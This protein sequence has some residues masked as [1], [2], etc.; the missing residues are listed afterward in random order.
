MKQME[1]AMP[2]N[3]EPI[4]FDKL[5]NLEEDLA[6]IDAEFGEAI[7]GGDIEQARRDVIVSL[8]SMRQTNLQFGIALSRYKQYYKA[9]QN[10]MTVLNRIA[11]E[12]G[13][14]A[15]TLERLIE[16]CEHARSL[17][18]LVIQAMIELKINPAETKHAALIQNLAQ[19]PAPPSREEAAAAVKMAN[20]QHISRKRVARTAKTS[21]DSA[22]LSE[23][24]A[25]AIRLFRLRYRETISAS[26]K[27]EIRQVLGG[28]AS[29]FEIDAAA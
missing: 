14:C 4:K 23:F 5:S 20:D 3:G 6:A 15:R 17:P 18:S 21:A 13:R 27:A 10:W 8:D 25:K 22:P 7:E 28:I 24:E 1:L 26:A 2:D 12:Y 29:A 16:S 11:A 9:T 19:L